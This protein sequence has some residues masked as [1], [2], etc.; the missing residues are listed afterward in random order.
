MSDDDLQNVTNIANELI[1][2]GLPVYRAT[3]PL[4]LAKSIPDIVFMSDE[5]CFMTGLEK[6]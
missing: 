6:L 4:H 3:V 5:V 2:S 1:T